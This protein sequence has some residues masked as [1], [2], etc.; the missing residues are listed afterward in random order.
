M[1][2]PDEPTKKKKKLDKQK[3]ENEAEIEPLVLEPKKRQY[4]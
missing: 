3:Q 1:R 2:F 4:L